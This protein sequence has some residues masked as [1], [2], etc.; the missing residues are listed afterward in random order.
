MAAKWTDLDLTSGTIHINKSRSGTKTAISKQ[1]T[2]PKSDSSNRII[3][4]ADIALEALKEEKAR[5][6]KKTIVLPECVTIIPE[7]AFYNSGIK[8]IYISEGV[9]NIEQS[10]FAYCDNL[11]TVVVPCSVSRIK[12]YA[13]Y[14]S[15]NLKNLVFVGDEPITVGKEIATGTSTEFQIIFFED[16]T[17]NKQTELLNEYS[18]KESKE[19]YL[20]L[21]DEDIRLKDDDYYHETNTYAGDAI[22]VKIVS[23]NPGNVAICLL[24]VSNESGVLDNVSSLSVDMSRYM[25]VVTFEDMNIQ[26][27]GEEYCE[28]KAFLWSNTKSAKPLAIATEQFLVKNLSE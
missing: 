12:D 6:D 20:V 15:A 17:W 27:V 16:S 22:D 8:Y 28:L 19:E 10:A 21:L 24:S 2:T 14:E 5:Q 26:Y 18:H 11:N 1:I 25:N 23:K 13:F 3:P 4:L 7:Y 9:T